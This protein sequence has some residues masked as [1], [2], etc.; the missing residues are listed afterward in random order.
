VSGC[1]Y[2]FGVQLAL[3]DRKSAIAEF[4]LDLAFMHNKYVRPFLATGENTVKFST[5]SPDRLAA[6]PVSVEYAWQEGPDWDKNEIKR[7]VQV[8]NGPA[9]CE[10]KLKVGGEKLPRMK[11]LTLSVGAKASAPGK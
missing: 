3:P 9:D 8:V 11:S 7:A 6:C 1:N 10:W 4:K 5:K 2:G